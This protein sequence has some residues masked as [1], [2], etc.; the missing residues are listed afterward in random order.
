MKI[1]G[2]FFIYLSFAVVFGISCDRELIRSGFP[3]VITVSAEDTE[4]AVAFTGQLKKYEKEIDEAGFIWQCDA[5]PL[6]SPGFKIAV[7]D[8]GSEQFSATAAFSF[9]SEKGYSVRAYAR[10]GE[11]MIFGE[12]IDFQTS[13]TLPCQ[14]LRIEP[15]SA[16]RG[17]TI[18]LLEKVLI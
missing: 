6:P 12:R 4:N 5:D 11:T 16:Y 3:F 10:C 2:L 18:K 15:E 9:S 8:P 17:D 1:R 7:I 13:L 14:L